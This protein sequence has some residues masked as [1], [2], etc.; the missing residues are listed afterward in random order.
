MK[1]INQSICLRKS[2]KYN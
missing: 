1:K 2:L